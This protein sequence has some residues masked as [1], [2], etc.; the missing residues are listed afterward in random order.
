MNSRNSYKIRFNFSFRL[1][2][3]SFIIKFMVE[4]HIFNLKEETLSFINRD[5][6]SIYDLNIKSYIELFC[7][8]FLNNFCFI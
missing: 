3:K 7:S 6:R 8:S 2:L 5:I 4:I 1:N